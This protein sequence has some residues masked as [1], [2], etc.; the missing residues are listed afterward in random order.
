MV[1]P[2]SP[3]MGATEQEQRQ[4]ELKLEQ[5]EAAL[6]QQELSVTANEGGIEEAQKN[7]D[8]SQSQVDDAQAELSQS[9]AEIDTAQSEVSK[10]KVDDSVNP[11]FGSSQ[12]TPSGSSPVQY[13][14]TAQT[15]PIESLS[16]A[17]MPPGLFPGVN[18]DIMN[19]IVRNNPE[20]VT[21][22]PENPDAINPQA[23]LL[24]TAATQAD[25]QPDPPKTTLE[26][27]TPTQAALSKAE[28]ELD[29]REIERDKAD[30]K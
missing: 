3:R 29:T 1:T 6:Q 11:S 9:K 26:I 16:Q 13:V 14:Y 28:P 8:E 2:V 4:R 30:R 15:R 21:M 7:L 23:T 19:Q 5:A 25:K 18:P 22:K 17:D 24:D 20:T 12:Q 10:A 27:N